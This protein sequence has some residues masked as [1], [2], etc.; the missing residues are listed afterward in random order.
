MLLGAVS[1]PFPYYAQADLYVHAVRYEGQS[2]AVQEAQTLGC[3]ILV[4]NYS[5][6]QYAVGT[7]GAGMI[8]E[9]TP[10]SIAAH[11]MLLLDNESMR[12]ELAMRAREK[13][14]PQERGK[15]KL[16]ELLELPEVMSIEESPREILEAG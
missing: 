7:E 3:P 12:A 5:G 4:S 2:I 16:L 1:N 6:S 13:K 9:L 15:E 11:I 10:Q 14:I 8:C